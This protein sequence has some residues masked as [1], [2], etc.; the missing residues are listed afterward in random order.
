MLQPFM[1]ALSSGQ[2]LVIG[3][4]AVEFEVWLPD[5]AS[6]PPAVVN[7]ILARKHTAICLQFEFLGCG[8]HVTEPHILIMFCR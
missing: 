7:V 3:P 2:S 4:A 8:H 5:F 1:C 6:R